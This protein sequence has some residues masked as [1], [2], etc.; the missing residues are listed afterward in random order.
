MIAILHDLGYPVESLSI[1]PNDVFGRILEPFAIDFS[2]VLQID[3]GSRINLLHQ[4]ICTLLSTMYRPVGL[5]NEQSEDYYK[6]AEQEKL[7]GKTLPFFVYGGPQ[8]TK[9][10]ALEMEYKI[11]FINKIHSAWS[12]TL[13]FKNISY[14]H[15]SDY[16]G[17]GNIDYL[18]LLSRRDILYSIVHHTFEEPKDQAVNRFQFILLLMDDIEE[19]LRFGKGGHKRGINS[20]YCDLKWEIFE[21]KTIIELD[22]SKYKFNAADKYEELSKKYK[23]QIVTSEKNSTYQII[24]RF[25]DSEYEEELSLYMVYDKYI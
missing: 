10:E 16:H 5:S 1:N 4:S 14:L 7:D 22:Y 9:D 23:S 19:T 6:K 20:E 25:I 15:E 3:L 12:A 8:I 17:G 13:A 18:K 2:S 21:D 11:A 24:L